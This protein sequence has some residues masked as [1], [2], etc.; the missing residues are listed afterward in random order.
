M[1]AISVVLLSNFERICLK[2]KRTIKRLDGAT[3]QEDLAHLQNDI[4]ADEL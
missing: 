1:R 2:W 4:S 3:Q